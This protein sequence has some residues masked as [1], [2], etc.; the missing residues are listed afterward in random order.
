MASG[1][2]LCSR[3]VPRTSERRPCLRLGFH[4]LIFQA[5]GVSHCPYH[6]LPLETQCTTCGED[7]PPLEAVRT[8]TFVPL[9]CPHCRSPWCD[10]SDFEG[11]FGV[12][13][14]MRPVLKT[15]AEI[16][17]RLEECFRLDVLNVSLEQSPVTRKGHGA[18]ALSVVWALH[19][20]T[21]V[22][23][24]LEPVPAL[25]W[26]PTFYPVKSFPLNGRRRPDDYRAS[27]RLFR[28]ASADSR[29]ID[30]IAPD[31]LASIAGHTQRHMPT[32]GKV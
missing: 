19:F 8:T 31:A 20:S 12:N 26:G 28:V 6:L 24:F 22:P 5:W 7:M 9:H 16:T 2:P 10:F 21:D 25:C 14:D 27:A 15:F 23:K 13:D 11:L 17:S 30:A 1:T 29:G 3:P 4:S 18:P 32:L